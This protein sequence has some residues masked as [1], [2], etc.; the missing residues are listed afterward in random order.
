MNRDV[1]NN[2][3]VASYINRIGSI[4]EGPIVN[5]KVYLDVLNKGF[6]IYPESPKTISDDNGIFYIGN[7]TQYP[8]YAYG[9]T[10][11]L[12]GEFLETYLSAPAKSTNISFLSTVLNAANLQLGMNIEDTYDNIIISFIERTGIQSYSNTKILLESNFFENSI[13]GY[14]EVYLLTS[15][16]NIYYSSYFTLLIDLI[17]KKYGEDIQEDKWQVRDFI[18]SDFIQNNFRLWEEP[19]LDIQALNSIYSNGLLVNKLKS[20]LLEYRNSSCDLLKTTIKVISFVECFKKYFIDN[21]II[22]GS[23]ISIASEFNN[24]INELHINYFNE[25]KKYFEFNFNKKINFNCVN[26]ISY[27]LHNTGRLI[28]ENGNKII[29]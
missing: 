14:G 13:A 3:A 7:R 16:M 9:G 26:T 24:S 4:I 17:Y 22:N 12:T 10:N 11:K 8:I 28:Q 2:S 25:Y 29:I 1:R 21:N 19:D 27:L 6:E 15:I 18:L 5:S 20:I 23:T